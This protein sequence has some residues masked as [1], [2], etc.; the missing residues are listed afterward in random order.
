[1]FIYGELGL[2]KTKMAIWNTVLGTS[3]T[4]NDS[5]WLMGSRTRAFPNTKPL[6]VPNL[7]S[8]IVANLD[9]QTRVKLA[10]SICVKD[11]IKHTEV[12]KDLLDQD[13]D[14]ELMF[15]EHKD[16]DELW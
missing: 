15:Q 8:F 12:N 5:L 10:W 9:S 11:C 2:F 16:H 3:V 14:W 4:A 13:L 6:S 1:M 7:L